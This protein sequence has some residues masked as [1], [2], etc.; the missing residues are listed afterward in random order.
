MQNNNA[1][2]TGLALDG[3]AIS[4]V[5]EDGLFA[6]PR[7]SLAATIQIR[8]QGRIGAMQ[9]DGALLVNPYNQQE[10][11][12]ALDALVSDEQLRKELIPKALERAKKF[13]WEKTARE[14]LEVLSQ[15]NISH[16]NI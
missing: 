14:T 13:D 7:G 5:R 4:H 2:G 10:L 12:T 11:T 6:R 15:K 3:A 9:G 8:S 16:L 1:T